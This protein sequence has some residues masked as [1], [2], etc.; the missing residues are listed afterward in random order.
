MGEFWASH[1][2]VL[3]ESSGACLGKAVFFLWAC[4]GA[5]YGDWVV[6]ATPERAAMAL[7]LVRQ[8]K[9]CLMHQEDCF[10]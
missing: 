10:H 9:Q 6:V 2:G 1:V 4:C 7:A 3:F 8:A 5:C